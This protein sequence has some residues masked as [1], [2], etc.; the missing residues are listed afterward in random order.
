MENGKWITIELH[1]DDLKLSHVKE[2]VLE[3]YVKM[4]NDRFKT[5]FRELT[6]NRSDVHDFLGLQLDYMHR[7]DHYVKLTMCYFLEDILKEVDEKD[8]MNGKCVTPAAANLFTVV[9]TSKKLSVNK[10]DYFHRIVAGLLFASKRARP[11]LQVAVAYVCTR[12][13]CPNEADYD[14]LRR[15]IKYIRRTI[16]L[17]LLLGWGESGA[18]K[19]SVDASF[20]IHN[21]YWLNTG[22]IA[23]LK[24]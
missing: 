13:K 5:K 2:A 21:D 6:V 7:K 10:A 18:F 22:A 11:D 23:T 15:L 9:Q 1:V 20:A 16:H 24:K 17:P 8:D 4:L 3:K 12:V 14:K 19:W